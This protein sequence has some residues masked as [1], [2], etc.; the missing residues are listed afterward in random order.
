MLA[1]TTL[2]SRRARG[3][4][5]AICLIGPCAFAQTPADLAAAQTRYDRDIAGCNGGTLPAPQREACIREAGA[6]LDRA[7]GGPADSTLTTSRDGRASIVTPSPLAPPSVT[8]DIVI[9]PDGRASV[10]PLEK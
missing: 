9:S 8:P 2:G 7:R 1:L 3:S 5:L 10:V 6:A 4:V